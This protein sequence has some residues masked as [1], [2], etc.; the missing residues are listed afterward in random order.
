MLLL[1]LFAAEIQEFYDATLMDEMKGLPSKTREALEMAARWE[2]QSPMPGGDQRRS[3]RPLSQSSNE[4]SIPQ[5]P[6]AVPVAAN[7]DEVIIV[8]G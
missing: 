4:R 5:S 3:S 7:G 2:K 8:A 1:V 6:N